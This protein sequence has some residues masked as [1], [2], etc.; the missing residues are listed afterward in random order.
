MNWYLK[1][2]ICKH[3]EY[4]ASFIAAEGLKMVKIASVVGGNSTIDGNHVI[5]DNQKGVAADFFDVQRYVMDSYTT[6]VGI[7]KCS[8]KWTVTVL[9][10]HSFLGTIAYDAYWTFEKKEEKIASDTYNDILKI[11]K[12]I[13]ERFARD[14]ITTAIYWPTLKSDLE[15]VYPKYRVSTNIPWINYSMDLKSEPDWRKN[16]YG[17]RY[18]EYSESNFIQK[19]RDSAI[20]WPR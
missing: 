18:P 17:N 6:K 15:D 10:T 3:L 20:M 13:S 8:D 11:V 14:R 5:G 12:D 2:K 7:S 9:C 16:I 19:A 1:H 4:R